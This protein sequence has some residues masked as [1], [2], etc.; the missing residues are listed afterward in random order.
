MNGVEDMTKKQEEYLEIL[1]EKFNAILDGF[2]DSA[3]IE[4]NMKESIL[5]QFEDIILSK[6]REIRSD[7][8]HEG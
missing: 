2:I 7:D 3:T 8:F 6:I 4:W 5:Y 1:H